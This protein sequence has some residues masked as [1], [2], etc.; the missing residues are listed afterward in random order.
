MNMHLSERKHLHV[1]YIYV[2][3]P[4]CHIAILYTVCV[5]CKC[6]IKCVLLLVLLLSYTVSSAIFI[7]RIQSIT[8]YRNRLLPLW[9]IP[10]VVHRACFRPNAK[11]AWDYTPNDG[12]KDVQ[13][14]EYSHWH[15]LHHTNTNNNNNNNSNKK[16][17][18]KE[19]VTLKGKNAGYGKDSLMWLCTLYYM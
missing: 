7:K 6:S 16:A 1:L 8:I 14:K 11:D 4:Y 5:M 18:K 2:L 15:K 19:N 10:F 12:F 17:K 3:L 9:L 13:K